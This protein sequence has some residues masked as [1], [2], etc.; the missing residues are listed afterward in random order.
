VSPEATIRFFCPVF[1]WT[2]FQAPPLA[3]YWAF[4]AWRYLQALRAPILPGLDDPTSV[5]A[6]SSFGAFDV[7]SEL[8]PWHE[9]RDCFYPRAV[10]D[11]YLNVVCGVG[12]DIH[13]LYTVGTRNVALTG[14]L[15]GSQG[16]HVP[17]EDEIASLKLYDAVLCP[18]QADVALYAKKYGVRAQFAPPDGLRA[19]LKETLDAA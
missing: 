16:L 11:R 17:K 8:S 12:N 3:N 15:Y 9:L 2:A 19:I 7:G 14:L 18:T 13:K 10:A 6:I 4:R 1:E 5:I